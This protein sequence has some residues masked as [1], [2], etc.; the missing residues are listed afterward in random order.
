MFRRYIQFRENRLAQEHDVFKKAT[1]L[2]W[3]LDCLEGIKLTQNPLSAIFEYVDTNIEKSEEFFSPKPTTEYCLS[4][5]LLTFPSAITTETK[6]NNIVYGRLF[7][8]GLHEKIVLVYTH[9]NALA[10]SY[11]KLCK[12]LRSLGIPTLLISLPYHDQRQSVTMTFAEQMVSSN[13]GRTIQSTRQAVLDARL[14]LNWLQ[15]RGYR[16]FGVLGSSLGSCIAAILAAHDA[17]INAAVLNLMAGDFAEVVWTGRAT[18]HIRESIESRITLEDL[19]HA[20][21]IISPATYAHKL[22]GRAV[23]N[24][25]V[26]AKDD[27]VFLPYLTKQLIEKYRDERI[28]LEWTVLPCGH[29]TIKIFPFNLMFLFTVNRF[30]KLYL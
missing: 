6:E 7:E 27:D 8:T 28:K 24:L 22:R 29:Y 30:L 14:A 9:W 3:G 12:V 20:W 26:S 25:I 5:N 21:S 1:P 17:R 10:Q 19:K 16:R 13:I 2:E 18:Q 4:G 23:H 11:E 15:A